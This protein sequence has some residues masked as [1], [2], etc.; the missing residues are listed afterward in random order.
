MAPA[1]AMAKSAVCV[2]LDRGELAIKI[3]ERGRVPPRA[4]RPVGFQARRPPWGS[5][6]GHSSGAS[7]RRALSRACQTCLATPVDVRATMPS[8]RGLRSPRRVPLP[9]RDRVARALA[10]GSAGALITAFFAAG[11]VAAHGPVPTDPPMAATL[12]L[13]WTFEPLP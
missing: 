1:N 12:L 9:R 5:N 10:G 3:L 2:V 7:P 8:M 13:G 11:P 4:R 6:V